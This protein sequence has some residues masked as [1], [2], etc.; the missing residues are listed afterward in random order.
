MASRRRLAT[1]Y[2]SWSNRYSPVM[3]GGGRAVFVGLLGP[4]ELG[5]GI[6]VRRPG[7][8]VLLAVL[9]LSANRV[10]T[11]DAL[12]RALW[13]EDAERRPGNLQAQVY[14]LRLLLEAAEPGRARSRLL[15]AGGGYR[16]GLAD[17]GLDAALRANL[18][19]RGREVALAG[20]PLQAG[21]V[22]REALEL[23]RGPALADAAG[24]SGRLA[25]EAAGLEE[26]RLSVLEDR[27]DADL[28]VGSRGDLVGELTVLVAAH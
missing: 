27:I 7:L 9:A 22:L 6:E 3:D 12:I 15:T 18:A 23:W 11:M 17:G 25:T 5:A 4:V 14:Q 10:V 26:S 8:R 19:R 16:L 28:A 20:G 24:L 13:G 1:L 21:V 2:R